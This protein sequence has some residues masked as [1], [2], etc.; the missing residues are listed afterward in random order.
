M[1][2]IIL[3]GSRHNDIV[4]TAPKEQGLLD[5]VFVC[6]FLRD[7]LDFLGYDQGLGANVYMTVELCNHC[8][9]DF[10]QGGV[11]SVT[12]SHLKGTGGEFMRWNCV[13]VHIIN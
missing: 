11:R 2:I 4:P 9:K 5:P 1:A 6:A 3:A 12:Y 13:D 8:A 10:A 7:T